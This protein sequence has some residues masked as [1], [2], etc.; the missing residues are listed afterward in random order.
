MKK[1]FMNWKSDPKITIQNMKERLQDLGNR[2]RSSSIHVI[3]IFQDDSKNEEEVPFNEVL[4]EKF[5]ESL[6]VITYLVTEAIFLPFVY[7]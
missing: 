3:R 5:P 2:I 7:K 1:E 4:A 6:K